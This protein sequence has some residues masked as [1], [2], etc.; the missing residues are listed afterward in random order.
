MRSLAGRKTLNF[1]K[2][3]IKTLS[4]IFQCCFIFWQHDFTDSGKT[5]IATGQALSINGKSSP[6]FKYM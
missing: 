2:T 3:L 5:C 6:R 1:K 4:T